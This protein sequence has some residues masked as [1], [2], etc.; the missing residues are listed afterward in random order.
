MEELEEY[1][2]VHWVDS[3][4]NKYLFHAIVKILDNHHAKVIYRF[5]DNNRWDRLNELAFTPKRET[6]EKNDN[7]K[8]WGLEFEKNTPKSKIIKEFK[9][10]YPE[11]FI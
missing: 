3:F 4:S 5:N 2:I 8:F 9:E 7:K 6:Y 1:Y 10:K 11:H